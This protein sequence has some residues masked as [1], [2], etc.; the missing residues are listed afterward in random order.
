MEKRFLAAQKALQPG[1]WNGST[2]IIDSLRESGRSSFVSSG[3]PLLRDE[4]W[5]YTPVRKWLGDDFQFSQ[6]ADPGAVKLPSLIESTDAYI[7]VCVN[8]ILQPALSRLPGPDQSVTISTLSKALIEKPELVSENLQRCNP[9]VDNTFFSLNLAFLNNG[10]FIHIPERTVLDKPLYITDIVTA[11]LPLFHQPR[12]LIVADSQA[13]AT[14]VELR[15][16]VENTSLFENTVTQIQLAAASKVDYYHIYDRGS[17]AR[18]VRTLN[19]YQERDT[20]FSTNEISLSGSL[21][22][23]NLNF[24]PD[25]EGCETHLNGFYLAGSG[26]H[27]DVH[28]LVDHAKPNCVSN[29]LFKGIIDDDGTAVFN[30]RVLVRQDAQQ[31]NAYQSNRNVLLSDKAHMYSKPE[32]EIYADDVKCSHG[33]TTGKLDDEALFYLRSRG[34][35]PSI[36]RRMLLEAFASD[37]FSLIRIEELRV[38]VE[39][40]VAALLDDGISRDITNG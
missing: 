7:A 20:I 32:L 21:I 36:A 18:L 39:E 26:T 15:D 19:V 30:G 13:E 40:R 14:I 10:L 17:G 22:R 25:G 28:T 33:A 12:T 37:V 5:R 6:S 31:T 11:P 23:S 3:F 34:I 27:V 8:G 35:Q 9:G 38:N 4:Q 2:G 1:G 24:L 29:E 16:R